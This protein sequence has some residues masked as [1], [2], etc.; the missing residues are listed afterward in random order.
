VVTSAEPAVA[1]AEAAVASATAGKAR[2]PATAAAL[3][4]VTAAGP[5]PAAWARPA[6]DRR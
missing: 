5:E 2:E 1:S 4:S 6:K 3:I